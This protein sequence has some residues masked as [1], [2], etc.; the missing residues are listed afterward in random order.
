M[1]DDDT[2]RTT[3]KTLWTETLLEI[4][5]E[6]LRK[7]K[8]DATLRSV[9]REVQEKGYKPFYIVDKVRQKVDDR[10]AHRVNALLRKK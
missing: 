2:T 5:F 10:A 3:A 1:A 7:N 4:L 9:L 8:D 6:S